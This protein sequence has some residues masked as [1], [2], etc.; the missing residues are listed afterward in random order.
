M[1]VSMNYKMSK[2]NEKNWHTFATWVYICSFKKSECVHTTTEK[3]ESWYKMNKYSCV[4]SLQT[5][6][7]PFS[8]V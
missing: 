5:A 6:I 8:V 7:K 4:F 2:W 1:L 3:S